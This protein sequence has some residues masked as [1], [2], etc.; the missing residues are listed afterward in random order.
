MPVKKICIMTDHASC[1]RERADMLAQSFRD[2]DSGMTVDIRDIARTAD[3]AANDQTCTGDIFTDDLDAIVFASGGAVALYEKHHEQLNKNQKL[4]SRPI[5]V[6]KCPTS[7]LEPTFDEHVVN[8]LSKFG[9]QSSPI[10][11]DASSDRRLIAEGH[12]FITQ[13]E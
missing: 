11:L 12:R 10:M 2:A 9:M 5:G 6:V 1:T 13:I 7:Q 3:D 8:A 4:G